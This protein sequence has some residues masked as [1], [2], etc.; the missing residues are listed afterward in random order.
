MRAS[1]VGWPLEMN[2]ITSGSLSNS[3]SNPTS[4]GQSRR[5]YKRS[6]SRRMC[7]D[8]FKMA[9]L[10]LSIREIWSAAASGAR[11]RTPCPNAVVNCTLKRDGDESSDESEV[12]TELVAPWKE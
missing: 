8:L 6:V 5:K 7:F 10:K 9:Q 3:N 2:R 11:R 4:S 12:V 1:G